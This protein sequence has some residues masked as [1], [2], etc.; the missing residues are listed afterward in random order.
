MIRYRNYAYYQHSI[1]ASRALLATRQDLVKAF[2]TKLDDLHAKYGSKERAPLL[3]K[4][5][6]D[7]IL[8]ERSSDLALTEEEWKTLVTEYW[9][10]WG[11]KGSIVPELEAIAGGRKA[12]VQELLEGRIADGQVCPTRLPCEGC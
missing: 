10:R 1:V 12:W 11:S 9:T 6:L 3:A 7:L 8:V 4:L 2:L 5:E